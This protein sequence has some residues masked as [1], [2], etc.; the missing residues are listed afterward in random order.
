MRLHLNVFFENT[1][2]TLQ[3]LTSQHSPEAHWAS[4]LKRHVI[5]SQQ[6]LL[7]SLMLPQS[8]SSPE[9]TKPLPQLLP[10]FG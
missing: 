3:V 4:C 5:G 6:S 2:L 7:H 1:Q 10:P 8:H 9:S